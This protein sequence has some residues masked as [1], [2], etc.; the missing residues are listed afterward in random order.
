MFRHF[1]LLA[2]SAVNVDSRCTA[3]IPRVHD[4]SQLVAQTSTFRSNRRNTI[5]ARFGGPK[6][7]F[8]LVALLAQSH[9]SLVRILRQ[10]YDSGRTLLIQIIRTNPGFNRDR[11]AATDR[12]D[13]AFRRF[14]RTNDGVSGDV[15]SVI[16]AAHLFQILDPQVD[17]FSDPRPILDNV[18]A[19]LAK[20]V[21]HLQSRT[22]ALTITYD[23]FR[24][25]FRRACPIVCRDNLL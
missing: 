16:F 22:D 9:V 24:G 13:Q 17:R 19:G 21:Q 15:Q 10:R 18:A 14:D 20:V 6:T 1:S 5:G 4:M 11:S 12:V 7:G 8:D 2:L 23:R 3:A 25:G